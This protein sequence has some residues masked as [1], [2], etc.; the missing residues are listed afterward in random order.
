MSREYVANLHWIKMRW[1]EIFLM[2]IIITTAKYV[3]SNSQSVNDRTK[4]KMKTGSLI[5][6]ETVLIIDL[7]KL[8]A[9]FLYKWKTLGNLCIIAHYWCYIN[10]NAISPD[11]SRCRRAHC[12]F[13]Y[14]IWTDYYDRLLFSFVTLNYYPPNIASNL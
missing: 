6:I 2:K 1:E 9:V 8:S 10:L 14:W 3:E 13:E 7:S 5:N 4:N 11:S 12:C